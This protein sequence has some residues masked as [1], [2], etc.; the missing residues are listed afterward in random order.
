LKEVIGACSSDIFVNKEI[1]SK[2]EIIFSINK[3]F[4]KYFFDERLGRQKRAQKRN[5]KSISFQDAFN[6][7]HMNYNQRAKDIQQKLISTNH[8]D[9]IEWND[10]A[11]VSARR[12]N[13]SNLL[14]PL[15]MRTKK[16]TLKKSLALAES[17]I[18][19]NDVKMFLSGKEIIIEGQENIFKLTKT[20]ALS[21]SHGG[22]KCS[23]FSKQNE[24]QFDLCIYSEDAPVL[25]HLTS[26][27]LHIKSG[28]ESELLSIGNKYNFENETAK[29]I[30]EL[31]NR[32][33]NSPPFLL[34]Y[35]TIIKRTFPREYKKIIK[36]IYEKVCDISGLHC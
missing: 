30:N 13:T 32:M 15:N 21:N 36:L 1:P 26:I 28:L 23:V 29:E 5:D 18:S 16:K 24:R 17:V 3:S 22:T 10:T 31:F 35:K 2:N 4:D 27:Y 12:N 6:A 20:S 19:K 7:L 11:L 9:V 34:N 33:E 8:S 14:T 25:D